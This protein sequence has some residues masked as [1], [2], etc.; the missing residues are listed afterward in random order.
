MRIH[1]RKSTDQRSSQ[2]VASPAALLQTLEPAVAL[3]VG[4][5]RVERLELDAGVVEVVVDDLLAEGIA[6]DHAL[7]EEVAGVAQGARDLRAI[8]GRIGV[9]IERRL[10][11]QPG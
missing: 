6:G 4:D 3:P 7:R 11:L 8:G 2:R 5:R 10:E 1:G 9:A